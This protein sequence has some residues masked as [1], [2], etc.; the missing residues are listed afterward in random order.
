M[1]K[2]LYNVLLYCVLF[3]LCPSIGYASVITDPLYVEVRALF[4]SGPAIVDSGNKTN[5]VVD[6]GSLATLHA[7]NEITLSFDSSEEARV[8]F[9]R[10]LTRA[11]D[12]TT[13]LSSFSHAWFDYYAA[14]DTTVDYEWD[15]DYVFGSGYINGTI[16]GGNVK[17]EVY[18]DD[19]ASGWTKTYDYF[20]MGI[21]SN[22]LSSGNYFGDE[23]FALTAG[24]TF[25]IKLSNSGAIMLGSSTSSLVGDVAFTFVPIPEPTTALLLA[26]GLAGLAAAGR[27]RSH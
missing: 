2:K 6:S 7:H 27:R 24:D 16:E 26:T 20:Q 18:R 17:L 23:T 25:R 10:I 1:T 13:T 21:A 14:A 8:E 22:G 4:G 15:L 5:A 11:A 19:G 9:D 12:I 3:M